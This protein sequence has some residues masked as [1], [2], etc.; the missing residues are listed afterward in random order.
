MSA[1]LK[2][3]DVVNGRKIHG[4]RKVS[5]EVFVMYEIGSA[6]VAWLQPTRLKT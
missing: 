6:W 2:V 5:G 3:G 4:V 1:E